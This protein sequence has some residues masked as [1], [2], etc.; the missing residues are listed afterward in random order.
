[1]KFK[2][3]R[4][5]KFDRNAAIDIVNRIPITERE[6]PES[7]GTLAQFR[8]RE[9]AR[10][11]EER[12]RAQQEE[13]KLMDQ[14]AASTRQLRDA[15]SEPIA[16]YWRQDLA[17]IGK[18]GIGMAMS[19]PWLIAEKT[20]VRMQ[21]AELNRYK[22]FK[23]ELAQKGITLSDS[24]WSR[25]GSYL[26]VA[27]QMQ[28]ADLTVRDTW[29]N[30]LLRL[31][32]LNCFAAGELQGEPALLVKP[33]QQQVTPSRTRSDIERELLSLGDSRQDNLRAKELLSELLF[34]ERGEAKAMYDEWLLHLEQVHRFVPS[35]EQEKAVI[36]YFRRTNSSYVSSKSYNA[37]R[38]ALVKSGVFPQTSG[39]IPMLTKDE[40]AAWD[41]DR[42]NLNDFSDRRKAAQLLHEVTA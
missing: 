24:G 11:A 6:I 2:K 35:P 31:S 29:L 23:S 33:E 30:A 17:T 7:V 18:N 3:K 22:S 38:V 9:A 15:E 26:T 36:E 42:L 16:A 8:A 20:A 13:R 39:N 27:A 34:G 28:Q 32:S 41:I 12:A 4:H 40:L 1:M 5:A 37:C 25:L 21:D 19:D 10:E 14:I